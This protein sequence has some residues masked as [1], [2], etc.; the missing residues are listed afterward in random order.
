[1]GD[2]VLETDRLTLRELEP[3]D[4]DELSEVL[5]DPWTMRFYRHP[6]SREEVGGWIE[7]WQHS[8]RD[9]GFGLWG[10]ELRGDGRLVGDTGLSIQHVDGED[11]VEV[12]WHVHREYQRR[13]LATEAAIAAV[14]HGFGP[15][16]LGR[17]ISLIRPENQP[18]WRV[19][20]KLGMRIWKE[21]VRSQLL[22]LV[23]VIEREEWLERQ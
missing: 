4:V 6:F 2:A 17:I 11:L 10:L 13:G 14:S 16:G 3:S 19:A 18:S 23:Y 21:T 5:S 8:Y 9:N 7:R 12:G 15:L 1:V 20:E 22:H